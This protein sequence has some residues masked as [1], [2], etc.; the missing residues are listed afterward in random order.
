MVL[1]MCLGWGHLPAITGA[2]DWL[3]G[4]WLNHPAG[5]SIVHLDLSELWRFSKPEA[6]RLQWFQPRGR[7]GGRQCFIPKLKTFLDISGVD[8]NAD[9]SHHLRTVL[10]WCPLNKKST[11]WK[12]SRP[13]LQCWELGP[14]S[15]QNME[16]RGCSVYCSFG[17]PLD[18]SARCPSV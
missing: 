12:I 7:I 6:S 18:K 10:R 2:S 8:L 3:P 9:S 14:I 16:R 13:K 4:G 5:K 11:G 17:S 1:R 15:D